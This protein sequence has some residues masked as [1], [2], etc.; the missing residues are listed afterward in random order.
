GALVSVGVV[1]LVA[2][3]TRSLAVLLLAGLAIAS[4]A[5][6]LTTLAI[7]LAP[8]PWAVTELVFWLMGSIE[9]RSMRHV[10]MAAPFALAGMALLL[11]QRRALRALALGEEA[12]ETLGVDVSRTTRII[13]LGVALGVG[14]CVA[15]SG[16]IGFVG[17]V[18]A[19]CIR[20]FVAHDPG[21]TV[22]PAA[23]AGALIILAADI[24]V[25]LLPTFTEVKLGVV[26]ALL[27]VP[28]FLWIILKKPAS[29]A[30]MA[31]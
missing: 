19:H 3:R 5:G 13:V 8:N 25:R 20:P 9:D 24:C 15:V 30:E 14:A 16:A 31:S 28:F 21:R 27:G 23:L 26:T 22:L 6:A 11:S 4:F 2:Q 7:N 1:T 18:A 12:A 17:L 29:A 10:I